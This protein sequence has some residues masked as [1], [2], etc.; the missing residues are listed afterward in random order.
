MLLPTSSKLIGGLCLALLAFIVSEMAKSQWPEGTY[1]GAMSQWNA[2]FGFLIGWIMLGPRMG[3]GYATGISIGFTIAIFGT[4]VVLLIHGCDEMVDL[5]MRNRY[6]GFMEAFSGI[7]G[8]AIDFGFR[9]LTT[10]ALI[11][12]AVGGCIAGFM[13][14]WAERRWG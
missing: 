12:I 9:A 4:A 5:A 1:F 11:T 13:A 2:F 7:F 8:N 10:E 14:E 3:G 6:G